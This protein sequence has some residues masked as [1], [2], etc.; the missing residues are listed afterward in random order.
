MSGTERLLRHLRQSFRTKNLAL[1]L[2]AI[3][4]IDRLSSMSY[5]FTWQNKARIDFGVRHAA[6]RMALLQVTEE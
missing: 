1:L 2:D 5:E 6:P 4:K 3:R